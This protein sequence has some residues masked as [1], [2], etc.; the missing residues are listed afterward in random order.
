MLFVAMTLLA[1]R[2]SPLQALLSALVP[3]TRP[4]AFMSLV[5]ATGQLGG[6]LG[7][8]G[9]RPAPHADRLRRVHDRLGSVDLITATLAW[10]ELPEPALRT[11]DVARSGAP[12]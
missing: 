8:R 4:G 3:D 5:V 11:T 2:L 6:G 9:G 1:L 10:R 7:G 12:M